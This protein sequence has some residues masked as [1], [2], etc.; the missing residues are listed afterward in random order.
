M[1]LTTFQ[2]LALLRWGLIMGKFSTAF[3]QGQAAAESAAV[4]NSEIDE[5]FR[6]MADELRE[7]TEGKLIVSVEKSDRFLNVVMTVV[8]MSTGEPSAG[9]SEDFWICVKNPTAANSNLVKLARFERPYEG[10]PCSIQYGKNDERCNDGIAL[11]AALK[12]M[13]TNAWVAH[14]LREVMGRPPKQEPNGASE[15]SPTE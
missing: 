1:F 14:E 4:A 12:N 9:P 10:Y 3:K 13:L 7:I 2:F 11:A 5:I 8:K 6:E 15:S